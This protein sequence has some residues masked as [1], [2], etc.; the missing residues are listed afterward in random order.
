[1]IDQNYKNC[2]EILN[3]DHIPDILNI[4]FQKRKVSKLDI[5][6]FDVDTVS[7]LIKQSM[8]NPQERF[9]G[10]FENNTLIS[11][12]VQVINPKLA[13]WH[14]TMLATRSNYSWNYKK[15]GLEYCW[16]NA[17]DYAENKGIYKIFW[18]LP[19]AWDRTQIKTYNTT[20]VWF[21]YN[22]YIEDKILPNNF[23]NFDEH[24]ICF[25]TLPKPHSVTI[26]MA[27]LKNEHRPNN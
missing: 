14:M 4:V 23:P 15:N 3:V 16:A 20:D 13:S 27:V 10:Y 25:G 8:S 12:L 22:I 17:M 2:T 1:M 6:A 7:S 21:R 24:K 9:I 19:S 11:F 26:K 5:A 18:S